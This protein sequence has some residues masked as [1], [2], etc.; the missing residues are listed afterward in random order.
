MKFT[1]HKHQD[2]I[3]VFVNKQFSLINCTLIKYRSAIK[4][5]SEIFNKHYYLVNKYYK[6]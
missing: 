6:S 2:Y 1:F 5:L 4:D 3:Q